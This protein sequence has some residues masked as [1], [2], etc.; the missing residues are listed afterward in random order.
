MSLRNVD[1]TASTTMHHSFRP[2]LPNLKSRRKS[3]KYQNSS[4]FHQL[5]WSEIKQIR[6]VSTKQCRLWNIA[7]Y[8]VATTCFFVMCCGY[9]LKAYH[10]S[11]FRTSSVALLSRQF[12]Q[13]PLWLYERHLWKF[14]KPRQGDAPT[15]FEGGRGMFYSLKLELLS[16]DLNLILLRIKFFPIPIWGYIY[17]GSP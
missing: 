7:L 16:S 14:R 12:S 8:Y 4:L 1:E 17:L 13:Q 6:V 11:S 15:P 2:P 10:F 3:Q 9:Q 5:L